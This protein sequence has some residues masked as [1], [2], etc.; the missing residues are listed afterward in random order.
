MDHVYWVAVSTSDI[1]QVKAAGKDITYTYNII[2]YILYIYIIYVCMYVCY[3]YVCQIGYIFMYN[4]CKLIVDLYWIFKNVNYL[5]KTCLK[6][7]SLFEIIYFIF[8]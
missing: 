3:I 8:L 5:L 4:R 2:S 1:G 6:I 7:L